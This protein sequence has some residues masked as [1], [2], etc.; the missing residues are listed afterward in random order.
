MADVEEQQDKMRLL[1]FILLLA[2]HPAAHAATDEL[3]RLFFTPEKRLQ[4]EQDLAHGSSGE[5]AAATPLE[6]NGIV[7]QQHGTRTVW[8][9]GVPKNSVPSNQL[10]KETVIVPGKSHGIDIKVGEKVLLAPA[11]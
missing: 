5:D 9:N 10:A 11:D 2:I 3:G 4:L 7:Q 8:I 1:I 6:L